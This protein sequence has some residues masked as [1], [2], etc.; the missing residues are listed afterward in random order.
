M[1]RLSYRRKVLVA[2]VISQIILTIPFILQINTDASMDS[3]T[4]FTV[5]QNDTTFFCNN[6]DE[7]LRHGRVWFQPGVEGEYGLV[8][9]GY[10]IYRNLVVPVGGMNDQGLC[11]DMT[12]VAETNILLNPEKPDYQGSFFIDMLR[13]CATVEEAKIWVRSFDLLLLNWQQAHVADST[14]DAVIF[15]LDENGELWM[16]NKTGDYIVTTNFNLAQDDGSHHQSGRYETAMSMLNTMSELTLNYCQEILDTV[17]MSSTMYSYIADL[18]NRILYLYSRGDFERVATLNVTEEL[19][20]G[21]HSYDIERLVSQQ[22]DQPSSL[23]TPS[24]TVG[25]IAAG[26]VI[27]SSLLIVAAKQ[28]RGWN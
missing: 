3:C 8:L 6:E 14:G 2:F 7:G 25:V 27:T 28:R 1:K 21:D 11:L 16:T 4:I 26:F 12:M 5:S 22:T 19:A 17:S 24:D 18:Q 15:G 13:V 10:A 9:F 20:A 23:D